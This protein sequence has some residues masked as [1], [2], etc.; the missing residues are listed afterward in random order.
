[1]GRLGW[2]DG[3]ALMVGNDLERDL[4]PANALQIPTYWIR[5]AAA[6]NGSVEFTGS[7]SLTDLRRWLEHTDLRRLEPSFTRRDS[8]IACLTAAPASITSLLDAHPVDSW[9]VAPQPGEWALTE[10]LCHLRDTDVD[11]NLPRL[12]RFLNESLPFITANDTNAWVMQ[13]QYLLQDGRRALEDFVAARL[14][15]L[16][17]LERMNAADW[18]RKARHSIFGPT[19]LLETV[20]FMAEHDRLHIQQIWKLLHQTEPTPPA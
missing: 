20:G 12:Q 13:R 4:A 1:M 17:D 6:P 11:V 16:E 18:D 14:R 3:P 5:D 2:P 15:L 8:I 7:G 10:V 19:T 9:A